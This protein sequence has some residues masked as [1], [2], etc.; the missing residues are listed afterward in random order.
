MTI[1]TRTLLSVAWDGFLY[2]CDFNQAAGLPMANKKVHITEIS[3][4]PDPDTP[5]A[6]ADHCYTCTAGAGFT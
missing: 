6:A 1:A 4:P 2:D 3:A 5:I